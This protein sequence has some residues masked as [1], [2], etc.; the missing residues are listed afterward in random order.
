MILIVGLAVLWLAAWALSTLL[1]VSPAGGP[2]GAGHGRVGTSRARA[3]GGAPGSGPLVDRAERAGAQRR[4]GKPGEPAK[5][6][7]QLAGNGT[8][9][10]RSAALPRPSASPRSTASGPVG[11]YPGVRPAF[12]GRHAVVLSL[13]LAQDRYSSRQTPGFDLN[14]VSTQQVSCSFNVGARRLALVIT[15]GSARIWSSADCVNG[16]GELI[17]ELSRGVPTV[18]A[19]GWNRVTSSPGCSS[20][21]RRVPPGVYTAYAVDGTL[22]SA[23]VTFRLT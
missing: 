18:L 19:I 8:T 23:P 10:A 17:T 13:F 9:Q 7:S 1:T 3:P 5:R 12:C 22:V 11:G 20:R 16:V 15:E 14:V 2:A 21:E 6:G 4:R